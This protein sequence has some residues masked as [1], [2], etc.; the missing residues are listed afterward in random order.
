MVLRASRPASRLT[1]VVEVLCYHGGHSNE[2]EGAQALWWKESMPR[3]QPSLLR[4]CAPCAAGGV[5][6]RIRRRGDRVG[7][8]VQHLESGALLVR[9]GWAGCCRDS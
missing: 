7:T 2:L 3:A 9:R 4:V 6:W 8:T 1:A 5:W